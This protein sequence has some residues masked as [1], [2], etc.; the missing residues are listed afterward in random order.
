MGDRVIYRFEDVDW[1][2]PT[3]PG[4]DPEQA[5]EA[6]RRGAGRKLLAQ[7]DGGFYAQIVQIPPNFEVPTHS[8][9]H[10]E[11]FIVL[12]GGCSFDGE[13][14]QRYDMTVVPSNGI[15]GFSAGPEGVRFLVVRTG[16][17]SYADA[18]S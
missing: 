10:S 18:S 16:A 15:Y 17:A 9:S 1:H 13:E 2:V 3:A 8:H 5:E 4:T 11:I 7:G 12:E 6:G 14:M